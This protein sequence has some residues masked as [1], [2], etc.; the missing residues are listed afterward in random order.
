MGG[1]HNNTTENNILNAY[2]NRRWVQ[3]DTAYEYSQSCQ[4]YTVQMFHH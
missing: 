3:T 1:R 4:R 2:D